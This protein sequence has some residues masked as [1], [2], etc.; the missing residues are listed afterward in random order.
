MTVRSIDFESFAFI[1][2]E[3]Q[4]FIKIKSFPNK[5]ALFA[6]KVAKQGFSFLTAKDGKRWQ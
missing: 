1:F 3:Q 6:L 2:N 5:E 4:D